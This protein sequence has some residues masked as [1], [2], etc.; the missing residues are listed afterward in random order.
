[1]GVLQQAILSYGAA[2][3][4]TD[5]YF[6][7]VASLLH[8]DGT[9]G[10]TT[11]TDEKGK[12]W[13]AG[14]NAQL[15][16]AQQKFGT[17]SLLLD[18]SG[19]YVTSAD[20][21][22]FEFGSGDLTIE[23]W[24]RFTSLPTSG[25][26]VTFCSKFSGTT[27]AFTFVLLNSAGT[28]QLQWYWDTDNSGQLGPVAGNWT[29]S[30]GTWYFVAASRISGNIE[31]YADT[32]RIVSGSASGV[33]HNNANGIYVGAQNNGSTGNLNGWID[34]VRITKGIGR[35]TGSTIAIPTA[36]FPNS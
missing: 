3:S 14:G 19:D 24:V 5:P 29:P 21:A 25:N 2:A 7:S 17:A 22:D 9:D 8:F 36:A 27:H 32:N 10:S 33:I 23:M 20:H 13:T 11:F 1:M 4:P 15:D 35:Y 30:T 34:D 28:L 12:T 26:F 16:T 31:L 6:S 18:G